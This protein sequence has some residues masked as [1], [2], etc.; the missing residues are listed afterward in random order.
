MAFGSGLQSASTSAGKNQVSKDLPHSFSSFD[1]LQLLPLNRP[2]L[3]PK[4][5]GLVCCRQTSQG[6]RQCGEEAAD[7]DGKAVAQP[8]YP[9]AYFTSFDVS[10]H[11]K[12]STSPTKPFI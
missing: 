4:A 5:K 3:K 7:A 8:M 11:F 1:P 6:C 12:F 2:N 9:V 10:R